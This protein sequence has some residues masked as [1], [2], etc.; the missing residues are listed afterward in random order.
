MARSLRVLFAGLALPFPPMNGHRLRTWAMVRALADDGHRVTLVSFA[1]R[2]EMLADLRPLHE[3]CTAVDLVSTPVAAARPALEPLRRGLALASPRPFGVWKLRSTELTRSLEGRLARE[4]FDLVICDGIYNMQNLPVNLSVPVVL[5]KDD[6]AHLIVR[7]FLTLEANTLRRLY[8]T[9][10]ARKVERWERKTI[11][12]ARAV[13]ACSEVDRTLLLRLWPTASVSV[14][15]N[16]VDTDHYAPRSGAESATVLFQGGMDWHPNRD[17]VEF[18]VAEVLPELQRLV[19]GVRFR[20][21]GRSPSETFRL[22]L[23]DV[24][25]VEFT[26]TVRDMRDEIAKATVCVV[27]LRIG[28]GTRLKILEAGAM[29]KPIVS[30]SLGAEGLELVPGEEIVLADEPRAFAR[31]VAALLGDEARRAELGRAA[32]LQIVKQYSLGVFQASLREALADA[33]R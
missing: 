18:F 14:V 4:S 9:L 10:E 32:R 12:R 7:R 17:A 5:N 16:A 30:T 24:P 15:P 1:E 3:L 20:V 23:A 25:G 21:A 22:H 26:G 2:D 13:L 19:R 11:R 27:P 6:V 28:S 29:A 31:S 8:G 33:L